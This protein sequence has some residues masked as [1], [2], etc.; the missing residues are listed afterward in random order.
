[1]ATVNV[2]GLK[3]G[4]FLAIF[5]TTRESEMEKTNANLEQLCPL[6][7]S[8][9]ALDTPMLLLNTFFSVYSH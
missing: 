2:G 6:P 7:K 1:M 3:V 9:A 8:D 5:G 4:I